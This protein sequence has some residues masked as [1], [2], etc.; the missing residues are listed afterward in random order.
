MWP[1]E[2]E[3]QMHEYPNEIKLRI[4]FKLEINQKKKKKITKK[5]SI[6]DEIH[7]HIKMN[8]TKMN[9]QDQHQ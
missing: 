7:K 4:K 8:K 3:K 1:V 6:F 5:T 9:E 2:K